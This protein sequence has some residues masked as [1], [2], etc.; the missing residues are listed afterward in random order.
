M[1]KGKKIL[2]GVTGSIAAYKSADL[3][4]RLRELGHKVSVTMTQEAEQF[5]TPLTLAC[6]SGE[7]INRNLFEDDQSWSMSHIALSQDAD[8]LLIAPATANIIGKIACGIADDVLTCTALATQ[9][10]IVIVP[11]MNE[12]MFKNQIVQANIQKLK[13]IGVLFV[14]PIVG[15]LACNI[16]GEGHIAEIEDIVKAV[17]S[18]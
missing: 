17:N 11:A 9:A 16:V 13:D 18:I 14:N 6:L 2:L 7:K 10:K 12:G 3:I 4:R 15:K 5:I 8:I 1:S